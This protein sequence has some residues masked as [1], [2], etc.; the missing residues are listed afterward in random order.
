[1]D[2]KIF[3][4]IVIIFIGASLIFNH[5]FK[6][7]FPY[8]KVFIALILIFFGAKILINSFTK[9][10]ATESE[11][12]AVFTSAKFSPSQLDQNTAHNA[13]FGST[14]INLSNTQITKDNLELE[15]NAIFGNVKIFFPKTV[16]VRVKSSG[17]FGSVRTPDGVG[18]NFGSS[19]ETFGDG[20]KVINLE[21]NAV[22]GSVDIFYQ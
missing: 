14:I 7:N 5:L 17:V 12:N 16:K 13:V 4:G 2:S 9:K 21:A 19:E 3:W 18:S 22:F 11:S 8:L 15:V 1:M 6:F 20:T 10:N